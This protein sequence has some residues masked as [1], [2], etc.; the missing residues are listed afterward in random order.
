MLYKQN[1]TSSGC[2]FRFFFFF[3]FFLDMLLASG[4][5][6]CTRVLD[7]Y[8]NAFSHTLTHSWP[9]LLGLVEDLMLS[10]KP[11]LGHWE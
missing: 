10:Y 7:T 1:M 5:L 8:A 6:G 11:I 2:G 4:V 9:Y 3:F